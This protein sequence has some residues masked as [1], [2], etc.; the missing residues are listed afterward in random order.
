MGDTFS[1]EGP[2]ARMRSI[3]QFVV[4][5]AGPFETREGGRDLDVE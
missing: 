5:L 1:R 4:N 2:A 3:G